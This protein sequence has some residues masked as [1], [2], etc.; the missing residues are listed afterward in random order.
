M[1][2][3]TLAS[4]FARVVKQ[5]GQ[6]VSV[7][8]LRPPLDLVIAGQSISELEEFVRLDDWAEEEYQAVKGQPNHY[9]WNDALGRFDLNV[10]CMEVQAV[11]PETG[12][13]GHTELFRMTDDDLNGAGEPKPERAHKWAILQGVAVDE[14]ERPLSDVEVA[15]F[16]TMASFAGQVVPASYRVHAGILEFQNQW[17]WVRDI[18]FWSRSPGEYLFTDALAGHL[19][20]TTPCSITVKV[21]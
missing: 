16:V 4:R 2:E 18:W 17:G 11:H 14:K 1:A 10:P 6:I 7:Q 19:R 15:P 3:Q 8:E 13:P 20:I 5:G 21:G 12:A 9:L